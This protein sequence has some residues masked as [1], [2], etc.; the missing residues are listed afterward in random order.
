MSMS[1]IAEALAAPP[2]APPPTPTAPSNGNAQQPAAAPA[3][4]D[5]AYN[6][7]TTRPGEHVLPETQAQQAQGAQQQPAG[8]QVQQA[9]GDKT[10]DQQATETQQPEKPQPAQEP[11]AKQHAALTRR[12][13]A[14]EELERRAESRLRDVEARELKLKQ[15]EDE[16]AALSEDALLER[17]AQRKGLTLDQLVKRAITRIANG[18]KPNPEDVVHDVKRELEQLKQAKVDEA[19]QGDAEAERRAEAAVT[20]YINGTLEL[21]TEDAHPF[22]ADVEATELGRRVRAVA[23]EYA[24]KTGKAPDPREVLDY[25]EQQEG[26]RFNARAARLNKATTET[27]QG[28]AAPVA[29]AV[30]GNGKPEPPQVRTLSNSNAA[31]SSGRAPEV[32]DDPREHLESAAEYLRSLRR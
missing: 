16:F 10:S 30:P 17:V 27:P 5:R 32:S 15:A 22:L 29:G 12:K 24:S 2:A 13:A 6:L 8:D 28:A 3:K 4:P 9:Q 31:E 20:Q 23:E 25:L 1:Q 7:N 18:G 19:K 11:L 21:I 14:A 26:A